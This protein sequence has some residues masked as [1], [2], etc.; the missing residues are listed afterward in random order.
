MDPYQELESRSQSG[1]GVDGCFIFRN[2]VSL[3]KV[4]GNTYA[5]TGLS[6]RTT[7]TYK[8]V[9]IDKAGNRSSASTGVS[10]TT[11]EQPT[12]PDTTAPTVP[13]NPRAIAQSP[14]VVNLVWSAAADA[15]GS[16]LARYRIFRDGVLV[17]SVNAPTTSYADGG[18]SAS[19]TSRT[20]F[21][22]SMALVWSQH[23]ALLPASQPQLTMELPFIRPIAWAQAAMRPSPTLIKEG[24]RPR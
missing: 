20:V 10:V 17:T 2:D 16:V 22:R 24:C 1:S 19:T 9:A 15:G 6:A 8:V 18:R 12:M 4:S 21:L 23:A 14:S 11:G 13:M 7:Y 3:I 5:D